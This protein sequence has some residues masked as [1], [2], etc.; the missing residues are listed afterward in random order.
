[1]TFSKGAGFDKILPYS[2]DLEMGK[3]FHVR[4]YENQE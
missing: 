1:M 3:D 4:K 2:F